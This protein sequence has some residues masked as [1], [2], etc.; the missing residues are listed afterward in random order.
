MMNSTTG[1][2][3]DA[4]AEAEEAGGGSLQVI[5]GVSITMK[6]ALLGGGH[7]ASWRLDWRVVGMTVALVRPTLFDKT[8]ARDPSHHATSA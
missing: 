3:L 7:T 6:L 8:Q 2:I 4:M 1:V 5:A